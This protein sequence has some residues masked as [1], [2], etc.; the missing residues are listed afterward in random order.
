MR[1]KSATMLS[2]L[3]FFDSPQVMLLSI[4][5]NRYAISI[6]IESQASDLRFLAAEIDELQLIR[7]FRGKHDLRYLFEFPRWKKWYQFDLTESSS[8][9]ISLYPVDSAIYADEKNLPERWFFARDH[10]EKYAL[11]EIERLSEKTYLID[12]AWDLVDFSRFYGKVSD[13]YAFSLSLAKYKSPEV[14]REEKRR[15]IEACVEPPLRGGSSYINLFRELMRTLSS[16]EKLAVQSIQYASP[17]HVK[18]E[19][20]SE[21]FQQIDQ[22]LEYFSRNYN[23]IKRMYDDLYKFMQKNKLLKSD[24]EKFDSNGAIAGHLFDSATR[25]AVEIGIVESN[26]LY[27]MVGQNKLSYAK[28][29][30]AQFR[31]MQGYFLFYAEGRVKNG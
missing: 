12:G 31:R 1:K 9:S 20:K 19:G 10:T 16:S 2:T 8:N 11:E 17:G 3:V 6:A 13:L 22:D 24:K 5:E 21:V 29:V 25:L 26:H 27:E 18:I 14:N 28:V 4:K 23:E 7:Y 30:L 15:I